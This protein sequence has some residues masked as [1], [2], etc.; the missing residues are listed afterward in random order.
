MQLDEFS[1]RRYKTVF[2]C[3]CFALASSSNC[4][5]IYFKRFVTISKAAFAKQPESSKTER[6][7]EKKIYKR[8]N[9]EKRRFNN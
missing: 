4:D 2:F 6:E 1:T 9:T 3:L 5:K 8:K 7:N